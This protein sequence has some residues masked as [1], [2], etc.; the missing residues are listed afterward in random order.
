[1]KFVKPLRSSSVSGSGKRARKIGNAEGVAL[2]VLEY[3]I[4]PRDK[5]KLS[6]DSCIEGPHF[7]NAFMYLVTE[8]YADVC[9]PTYPR[10]NPHNASSP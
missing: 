4:E 3:A 10:R 8:E 1:M 9:S 2:A 7:N 6:L 5:L